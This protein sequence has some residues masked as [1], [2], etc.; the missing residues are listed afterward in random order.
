MPD[1]F[2]L[3]DFFA[4]Q[5]LTYNSSFYSSLKWAKEELGFSY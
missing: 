1:R 5:N 4:S 3:F 2:E